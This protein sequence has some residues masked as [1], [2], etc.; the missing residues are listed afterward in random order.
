MAFLSSYGEVLE[1]LKKYSAIE[2]DLIPH[3][4]LTPSKIED[5]FVR[6]DRHSLIKFCPCQERKNTVQI[7]LTVH[8]SRYRVMIISLTCEWDDQDE[9]SG[10]AG[11]KFNEV[12]DVS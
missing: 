7:V 1:N 12:E 5:S 8:A 10:C 3:L 4:L 6:F 9:H 11:N 2:K